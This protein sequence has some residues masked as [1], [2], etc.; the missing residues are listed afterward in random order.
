MLRKLAITTLI[1]AAGLG[2]AH[3]DIWRWKD[4]QGVFHYSDQ[5]VPGSELIKGNKS[6]PAS[7]EPDTPRQASNDA[8]RA[9][10]DAPSAATVQAVKADVAKTREQQC[11]DAKD[12]YQKAI[13]ARRITKAPS[14]DAPK[15]TQPEYLSDTEADA[16]RAQTRSDMDALCGAQAK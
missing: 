1:L 5:W 9:D 13:L 7:E 6:R 14:K 2:V 10:P 11:K 8:N 12:A 3:A 15:N 4:A 16:Y